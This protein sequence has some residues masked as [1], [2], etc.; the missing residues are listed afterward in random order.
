MATATVGMMP[1]DQIRAA[2]FAGPVGYQSGYGRCN[3]NIEKLSIA[4]FM[5]LPQGFGESAS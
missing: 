2:L 1:R 5:G 4:E 3:D